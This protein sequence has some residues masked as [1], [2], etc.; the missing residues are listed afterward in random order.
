MHYYTQLLS[1]ILICF[2]SLSSPNTCSSPCGFFCSLSLFPLQSLLCKSEK[3]EKSFSWK[4]LFCLYPSCLPAV[5]IYCYFVSKGRINLCGESP[6]LLELGKALSPLSQRW[7]LTKALLP[8]EISQRP[9]LTS[10]PDGKLQEPAEGKAC[11]DMFLFL[12][13]QATTEERTGEGLSFSWVLVHRVVPGF[14]FGLLEYETKGQIA[15]E[16]ITPH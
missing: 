12:K 11:W 13:A 9:R 3:E 14:L 7:S 2:L 6:K 10:H 15:F 8:G 4:L 1:V 16:W 5:H